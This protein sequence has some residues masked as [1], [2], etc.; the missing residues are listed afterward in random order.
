MLDNLDCIYFKE[1]FMYLAANEPMVLCESGDAIKKMIQEMPYID[2]ERAMEMFMFLFP[3]MKSSV[4]VREEFIQ[5]VREA[6]AQKC[7]KTRRMAVYGAC[8]L[9]KQLKV[10]GAERS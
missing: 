10:G 4:R 8:L 5:M 3:L 7:I 2:G 6:L 1:A 9:L